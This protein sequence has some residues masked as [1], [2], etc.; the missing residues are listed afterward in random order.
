MRRAT[1]A[2]LTHH[3][4]ATTKEAEKQN[5]LASKKRWKSGE[6]GVDAREAITLANRFDGLPTEADD[7]IPLAS[8]DES[9]T[10]D[11]PP[12]P[13]K[14]IW[15]EAKHGNALAC[16]AYFDEDGVSAVFENGRTSGSGF[17]KFYV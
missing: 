7:A 16:Q 1:D 14:R 5:F 13:K 15:S 10:G 17:R 12:A 11:T 3:N 6:A 9:S 2:L 4:S 8:S